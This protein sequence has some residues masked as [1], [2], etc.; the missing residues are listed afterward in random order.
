MRSSYDLTYQI[1]V[2]I[3]PKC[4]RIRFPV[5]NHVFRQMLEQVD[6]WHHFPHLDAHMK[7]QRRQQLVC[8]GNALAVMR[9]TSHTESVVRPPVRL[10][11][12]G[13]ETK[14]RFRLQFSLRANKVTKTHTGLGGFAEV[15]W[16]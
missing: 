6:L 14:G 5:C 9:K 16:V 2:L 4:F 11:M 13:P 15:I 10:R 8:T 7:L 12:G 1:F 3:R